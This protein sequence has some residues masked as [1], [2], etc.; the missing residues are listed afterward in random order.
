MFTQL[1]FRFSTRDELILFYT[2]NPISLT[3]IQNF[4]TAPGDTP[5]ATSP[6]IYT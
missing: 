2:S 1:F 3:K 5:G 4:F 6:A